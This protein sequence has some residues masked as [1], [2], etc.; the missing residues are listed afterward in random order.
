MG[1]NNTTL[2]LTTGETPFKLAFGCDAMILVELGEPSFKREH[3]NEAE[4]FDSQKVNLDL[5]D[6]TREIAHLCEFAVKQRENRRYNMKGIPREMRPRNLVLRKMIKSD[7][8]ENLSL[9]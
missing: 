2:H 9:N 8:A 1:Y 4:N 5:R 6:E 7:G 3:T